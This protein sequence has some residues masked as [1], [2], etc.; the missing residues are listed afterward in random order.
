[1]LFRRE[2][3]TF[4]D[5]LR[6]HGALSC[7]AVKAVNTVLLNPV[8]ENALCKGC[9]VAFYIV[10]FQN[11]NVRAVCREPVLQALQAPAALS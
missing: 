1:M 4:Y 5:A 3:H 7:Y 9:F 6:L 8:L 10:Y 11:F 2:L